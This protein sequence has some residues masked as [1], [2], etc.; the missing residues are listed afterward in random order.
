M[1]ATDILGSADAAHLLRRAGFG[2]APKD[3]THFAPLTR[4][5]AVAE[6]V[7]AKPRRS[8]PPAGKDSDAA[9]A[10]MQ[11]WWLKQM[12]APR[13][14]LHEKIALFWHAHFGTSW[15]ALPSS[16]KLARQNALFRQLGLGSF[17][18][19]LYEVTRDAAMLE[20]RDGVRSGLPVPNEN[21]AS[22]LLERYAL[23]ALDAQGMPNFSQSDVHDF[24]RALSGYRLGPKDLFGHVEPGVF[25]AG[26]KHVF[27]GRTGELMGNLG[28][29]D[30]TGAQLPP[31]RNV[32]DALFAHRDSDDR[33]TL[34]RFLAGRLWEWLAAPAPPLALVDELADAFVASQYQVSALV[35]AIL[36]HDDFYA[37]A[38]RS[39][40]ARTPVDFTLASLRALEARSSLAALP[41]A[42]RDMGMAL[43]DP[44]AEGW[45][46]GEAWLALGPYLARLQ[47]AQSLAAGRSGRTYSLNAKRLFSAPAGDD[48]AVVD[49]LLARLDVTPSAAGRQALLDYLATAV[50]LESKERL[51]RKLRGLVA[52]ALTLPEYQ[53]H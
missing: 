28:V 32:L 30:E 24:A 36:A 50:G 10:K 53:V 7:G 23:G 5:A 16:A 1:A 25:D 40:T 51:E 3:L 46:S 44:P 47:F 41:G 45:S 22:E 42:L 39:S 33:P 48:A 21:Y 31:E 4:A 2:A 43:F 35:S 37:A 11:V 26:Q 27:A 15:S 29:E 8:R 18:T 52:L 38:T 19:L 9:L 20:A 12:L 14:R 49:A 17:R 13:W 6:L 34:A